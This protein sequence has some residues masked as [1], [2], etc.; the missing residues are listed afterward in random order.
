VTIAT[1]TTS[2][3]PD[4]VLPTTTT[5]KPPATTTTAPT[6]AGSLIGNA[7]EV[8]DNSS[9]IFTIPSN[10]DPGIVIHTAA[11]PFVAYNAVC[12]HMGCTVGYSAATE[13]IVC[14]CHGSEFQVSD[15]DLIQGPA[16]RGLTKLN[17][18]EGSNGNLYLE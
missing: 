15:G 10:N 5:T 7:S 12:P 16:T 6:Q 2:T 4:T 9:A 18:V 3:T 13:I 14:P 17:V 8:P 11:G 1:T